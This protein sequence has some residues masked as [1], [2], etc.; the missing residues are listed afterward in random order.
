MGNKHTKRYTMSIF[1]RKMSI[2]ST[3]RS[4]STKSSNHLTSVRIDINTSRVIRVGKDVKKVK[5]LYATGKT[6]KWHSNIGK[7]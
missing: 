7:A 4:T 2:K 6:V 1:T 5:P 3:M